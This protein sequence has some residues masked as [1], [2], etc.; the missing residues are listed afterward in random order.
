MYTA[1]IRGEPRPC[2]RSFFHTKEMTM[3]YMYMYNEHTKTNN[4]VTLIF[5][6]WPACRICN[7]IATS[8]AL[9]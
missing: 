6:C 8:G 5:G 9:S 3:L 7:A 1:M 4:T 2:C